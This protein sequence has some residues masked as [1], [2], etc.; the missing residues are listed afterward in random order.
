MLVPRLHSRLARYRGYAALVLVT[1][2]ARTCAFVAAILLA[3]QFG[4][5]RFGELSIFLTILGFWSS[6][7]FLDSTFVRYAAGRDDAEA[8]GYLRA[9]FSLKTS[10]NSLLLVLAAPVAW[11]LSAYV[12]KKPVLFL[13]IALAMVCGAGL[14][15][16]SLRAAMHQVHE[17]LLRFAATTSAFYVISLAGVSVAVVAAGGATWA[18]FAAYGGSSLVVGSYSWRVVRR[19]VAATQLRRELVAEIARFSKWLFGANLGYMITQRL[20]VF[21]LAGIGTLAAVGEYGVALRVVALV[22]LLTGTLAPAL[23]PKASKTQRSS[24]LLASYLRHAAVLSAAIVVLIAGLAAVAPLAIQLLFG[25][26]YRGAALLVRVILVGTVA[27]AVYTPLSQ[28]FMRDVR[29]RKMLYLSLI[30][31]GVI[32]GAGV[33]LVVALGAI[34][35]AIAV[36]MAEVCVLVYVCIVLH[37]E[38]FAA[39]SLRRGPRLPFDGVSATPAPARTPMPTRR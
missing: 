30:R 25:A 2:V 4:P 22:S 20:D 28:L 35:A 27:I 3:R 7:D 15:M 31:F 37:A 11:L 17:D 9:V 34:G 13:A 1:A 6:P 21:L 5:E 38:V 39:L 14:N 32:L 10:W 18:V 26:D 24:V 36:A 19:A 33:P 16:L 12:F 23:L 8:A 29:P